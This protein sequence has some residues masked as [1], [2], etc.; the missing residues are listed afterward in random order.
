VE[1][2]D[3]P[4]VA[5]TAYGS[6]GTELL[7]AALVREPQDG[8]AVDVVRVAPGGVIGRHPTRLWQLFLVV[9]GSGWVSGASGDRRT[10]RAGEAA[11]WSPGEEHASGSD[12]GLTAVVVQ[13]RARPLPEEAA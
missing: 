6:S 10:L 8:F 5:L 11:V 7:R 4:G 3:V 9:S 1:V 13:C 2:L 12:D